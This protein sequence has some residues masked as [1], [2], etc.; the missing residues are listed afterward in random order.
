[1]VEIQLGKWQKHI[2]SG[3]YYKRKTW[4]DF[5]LVQIGGKDP[6]FSVIPGHQIYMIQSQMLWIS[7]CNGGPLTGE[8]CAGFSK[9]TPGTDFGST[10]SLKTSIKPIEP[11]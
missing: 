3:G 6:A 7:R 11:A 1:M 4:C 5:V 10:A 9:S 2:I 8:V